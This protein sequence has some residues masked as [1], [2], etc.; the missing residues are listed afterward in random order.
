[1]QDK[2]IPLPPESAKTAKKNKTAEACRE[3]RKI[4]NGMSE[5]LA[6]TKA[7]LKD[8]REEEMVN[9]RRLRARRRALSKR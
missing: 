8:M 5:T 9:L 7:L 2:T 3:M 4:L 1:M 6:S